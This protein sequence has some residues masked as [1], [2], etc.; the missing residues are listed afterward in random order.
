MR[1]WFEDLSEMMKFLVLGIVALFVIG[2]AVLAWTQYFGP[3]F[4]EQNRRQFQES[5]TH[6]DAIV[7]DFADKCQQ[8]AKATDDKTHKA[9]VAYIAEEASS[10]SLGKL[11]MNDF[12]RNCVNN[13]IKEYNGN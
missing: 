12:V 3:K 7:H 9:L 6:Q 13:A 2:G 10:E 11:Q 8:L 5:T 4:V 1:E